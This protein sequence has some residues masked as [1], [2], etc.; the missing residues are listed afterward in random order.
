MGFDTPMA[1]SNYLGGLLAVLIFY[2]FVLVAL[3]IAIYSPTKRARITKKFNLIC[4]ALAAFLLVMHMQ[5]EVIYGKELL[6][7]YYSEHGYPNE[8]SVSP[9]KIEVDNR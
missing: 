6:D 5:T 8:V 9:H 7:K 2:P 4:L 3:Q 1:I